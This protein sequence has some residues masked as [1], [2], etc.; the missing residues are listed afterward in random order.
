MEV[1]VVFILCLIEISR[2][3]FEVIIN[4]NVTAT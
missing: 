2:D 3:I 4:F 1:D